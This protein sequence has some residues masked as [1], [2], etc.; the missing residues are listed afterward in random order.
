[1]ARLWNWLLLFATLMQRTIFILGT[2]PEHCAELR[3]ALQ[4]AAA[5]RTV[6]TLV[7]N[8]IPRLRESDTI[9]LSSEDPNAGVVYRQ[10]LKRLD[11]QANKAQV[12]GDL[13]RRSMSSRSL[14]DS[15]EQIV[16]KSAEILGDTAFIVLDSEAKYQL[17]AAFTSD[18]D[19]LKK[20]LLTA[21]NVS[22]QA[23]VTELLR[24]TL[25]KGEPVVV[26]NL[27]HME[28]APELHTF[29]E[30]FGLFSMIVTP[31]R[32]RDRILGAFISMSTAP[33]MLV[34]QDLA[35]AMELADF[36]AMVIEN[37]RTVADLQRSATMDPL[38][39]VFNTRFFHEVLTREA[40]RSQRHNTSL[41]LL[42][43]DLD[44]FKVINDTHGHV[45]GDK[46]LVQVARILN[47]CVRKVD[48]VFRCGGDEF[49]VVLP[50]T[51]ADGALHVGEKI[52]EKIQ[53]SN[54]PKS[55]G[56]KGE[57]TV[58]IGIAEYRAG[59]PAESLIADA[60]QALYASKRESKN[61]IRIFKRN[62]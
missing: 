6:T 17:E 30:K 33:R 59:S 43:M 22:P 35:P 9:V 56:F 61:T 19:R 49:G 48:L 32:G 11:D 26:S 62:H 8:S 25:E 4:A 58:S 31:I 24:D 55:L 18:S 40:A 5:D 57:T 10:L 23:V 12:L 47:S 53:S 36:T 54:V 42:M 2:D 14:E 38:T 34:E 46:V 20:M 1:M 28:L 41:S 44:N 3:I 51:T 60:D 52:L 7:G 37:A 16:A 45:V 21:V 39:G 50:A 15:L 29:V 27:Q 13:I